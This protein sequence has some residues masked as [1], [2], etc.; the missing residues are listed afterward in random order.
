MSHVEAKLHRRRHLVD[1]LPSRSRSADEL[2]LNF[3]LAKAELIGN[4]NHNQSGFN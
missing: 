2:V 1:I 3:T 4:P